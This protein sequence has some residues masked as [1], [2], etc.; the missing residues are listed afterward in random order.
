MN[1]DRSGALNEGISSAGA[2][3]S[4]LANGFGSGAGGGLGGGAGVFFAAGK[5]GDAGP[6]CQHQSAAM[7]LKLRCAAAGA[8]THLEVR[9]QIDL[10]GRLADL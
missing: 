7:R 4:S 2:S 1:P 5:G 6:S 8:S 9:A 3:F 10:L